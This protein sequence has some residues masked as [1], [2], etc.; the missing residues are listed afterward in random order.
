MFI[1]FYIPNKDRLRIVIV[2]GGYSGL[3]ALATLR[4]HNTEA[5]I[6][7]IDPR[8]GHLK[9]TQLHESFRRPWADFHLPFRHLEH[10][11]GIRH[12][13][14]EIPLD[15]VSLKQL[16]ADRML[17]AETQLLEFDYLLIATGAAFRKLEKGE[18]TLDLDDFIAEPG[19]DL[20]SKHFQPGGRDDNYLTV[21]GGGASG[22]QFLFEIAHYVRERRMPCRLRLTDGED[23]PL[24]QFNPKLGR[25]AM[26]RLEDLG[27]EFLPGH[28]FR[29]QTEGQIVLEQRDNG[30]PV[31]LP[32]SLSLLFV[33][34]SSISRLETNWFGQVIDEGTVLDRVF[35]A[36]DCS[37]YRPPGSNAFSAQIAIRKGKLAARNIL[38]HSGRLKLL[39]PYV[40][41]ELGYVVSLGPADAVGWIA[42]QRN[43][44]GGAPAATIKGIVEAQYDLLL[45]GVDTYLL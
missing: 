10:R 17:A 9:I 32:S 44:V 27:I 15:E 25:Y 37:R 11:F 5:E 8:A 22:I 42:L 2:G 41:Q 3:A 14:A 39:E 7:L 21:V 40:H 43:V 4:E 34:K 6:I 38:R 24:T 28:F 23:A 12:I 35:A 36:G 31:A 20:L 16:N 29:S 45:A 30:E 26:A 18:R 33:G 19:P 13:Q 1:P